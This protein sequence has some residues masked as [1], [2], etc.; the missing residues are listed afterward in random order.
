MATDS[1]NGSFAP[2]NESPIAVAADSSH[3]RQSLTTLV[4]ILKFDLAT[5]D[6]TKRPI[7]E[8]LSVVPEAV[9][10][11]AKLA[12]FLRWSLQRSTAPE[13]G[14]SAHAHRGGAYP[15]DREAEERLREA[16][17][18]S[19]DDGVM[20]LLK[21]FSQVREAQYT[22]ITERHEKQKEAL[23]SSYLETQSAREKDA[24]QSLE[25][26][27][28][29]IKKRRDRLEA[30]HEVDT[31]TLQELHETQ[32]DDLFVKLHVHLQGKPNKEARERRMQEEL[33]KQQARDV[34]E[35]ERKQRQEQQTLEHS[36]TVELRD[37][38]RTLQ[39]KSQGAMDELK[40][41]LRQYC[42]RVKSDLCWFDLIA[43]RR[44]RML[45]ERKQV[46]I[47]ESDA[48]A[49]PDSLRV[50]KA[51]TKQPAQPDASRLNA[52][53]PSEHHGTLEGERNVT[54]SE[55]SE[56][57][58]PHPSSSSSTSVSVSS[59]PIDRK[60]SSASSA[61]E[62]VFPVDQ[63]LYNVNDGHSR[64]LSRQSS[65]EQNSQKETTHPQA[66]SVDR[67]NMPA[68]VHPAYPLDFLTKKS[69]R[70]DM[71]HW[72]SILAPVPLPDSPVDTEQAPQ[73]IPPPKRNA[74]AP[75]VLQAPVELAADASTA[76]IPL[77]THGSSSSSGQDVP[78][79]RTSLLNNVPSRPWK[80]IF[81][82]KGKRSELS[83]DEIREKMKQ[84]IGDAR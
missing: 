72:C 23:F 33:Q 10:I 77:R 56:T 68:P 54:L 1:N 83:E 36:T 59:T 52:F 14:H 53:P 38:E 37:V 76:S 75:P 29:I 57:T 17:K 46:I 67:S 44:Q 74:T 60:D 48:S 18:L 26:M 43:R 9:R 69:R 8:E 66:R 73:R 70:K 35:L 24:E 31:E 32:E 49:E 82:K 30:K 5:E 50:V 19:M 20:A 27:R 4:E 6:W 42:C 25:T 84:C 55:I 16:I 64:T 78:T 45:Q 28:S 39:M 2:C 79:R 63:T 62:V 13:L 15:Q 40:Y 58:V 22:A 51:P 34:V 81:G 7:P 41:E 61:P 12:E 21:V 65:T 71:N 11:P 80:G 3:T 47:E